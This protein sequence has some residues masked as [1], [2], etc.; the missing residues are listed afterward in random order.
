MSKIPLQNLGVTNYSKNVSVSRYVTRKPFLFF[1]I[2]WRGDLVSASTCDVTQSEPLHLHCSI[3]CLC[4]TELAESYLEAWGGADSS[5]V[6]FSPGC[7]R[8]GGGTFTP[9]CVAGGPQLAPR[10]RSRT[11]HPVVSGAVFLPG[12]CRQA[13]H[14]SAGRML[15]ATR[16]LILC[17]KPT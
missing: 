14:F 11:Q 5:A 7:Q 9:T 10:V 1:S 12:L 6:F 17:V 2:E 15:Q 13:W 16:H 3:L 4:P 8:G